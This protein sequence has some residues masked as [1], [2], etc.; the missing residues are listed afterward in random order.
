MSAKSSSNNKKSSTRAPAPKRKRKESSNNDSIPKITKSR[1]GFYYNKHTKLDGLTSGFL[2]ETFWPS[3]NYHAAIIVPEK[4]DDN[5]GEF[6]TGPT[7][8][9]RKY[10]PTLTDDQRIQEGMRRGNE[11]ESWFQ[12]SVRLINTYPILPKDL[13]A[14]KRKRMTIEECQILLGPTVTTQ[15]KDC[16]KLKKLLSIPSL[17]LVDTWTALLH[18]LKAKQV[19][20]QIVVGIPTLRLATAVD[21]ECEIGS[22]E[23]ALGE[24]KTGDTRIDHHTGKALSFPFQSKTDSLRHQYL[25]QLGVGILLYQ[26]W[27]PDRKINLERCFVLRVFT[28]G[29]EID[30][31]PNWIISRWPLFKQ[32]IEDVRK[33]K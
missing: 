28:G 27:H 12:N 13:F 2:K 25:I 5:E 22:N 8:K 1:K 24:L 6:D 15:D 30:F 32:R 3:Y 4:T 20:T 9:K 33:G 31:L 23:Y 17:K 16:T 26:H 10:N 18:K 14:Q 29:I 19:N 21:V 11:F 7:T